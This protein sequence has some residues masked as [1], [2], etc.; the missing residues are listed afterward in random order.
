MKV[1]ERDEGTATA[2]ESIAAVL[3]CYR[4]F[5]VDERGL[6]AESV[7]CYL[8]D[9][10]VFL[11]QLPDPLGLALAGL[12]AGQV[13]G[14]VLG[15]CRGRNTWSAKAMV[16]GLRS[17]LRFLHVAGLV[18]VPLVG[19]VPSVASWRGASLPRA[20]AAGQVQAMLASCDLATVVGRR[21][22]AVLVMLARLGLRTVEVARLGL[23]DVDWRSGHL[24]VRGKG[25]RVE[26][27]PLP[28]QVGQVLVDYLRDGRP[29]GDCRALFV[30][31]RAPR[32]ALTAMA[33]RQIVARACARAGLPRLGAHRLRHTLATD[34]LRAGTPLAQV[35][36]VLRHRS[37]LSTSLYAKVDFGALGEVARPWP[38]GVL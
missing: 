12:S 17:L 21:D 1:N 36:Q 8:L 30:R 10:R 5:L 14:F 15:Y 37:Q 31:V 38:G 4:V 2:G 11:T 35:G 24:L 20:L 33:V 9:A 19:A 7:R 25:D 26:R 18:P 13:T 3:D 29:S 27:L 32:V 23:D 22:H 28:V 16:T 6:A 34:M